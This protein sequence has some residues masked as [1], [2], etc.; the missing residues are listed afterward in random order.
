MLALNK[1]PDPDQHIELPCGWGTRGVKYSVLEDRESHWGS[2]IQ[3]GGIV[4]GLKQAG[5]WEEIPR[6]FP[7]LAS[8]KEIPS[9]ILL[10]Y[11][12]D[13]CEAG[14]LADLAGWV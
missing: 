11:T 12:A 7:S 13:R 4:L 5:G 3:G 9:G 1:F 8:T 2:P 14:A 6:I 10:P